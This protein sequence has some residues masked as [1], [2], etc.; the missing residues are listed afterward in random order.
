MTFMEMI[1]LLDE[2]HK[3]RRACWNPDALWLIVDKYDNYGCSNKKV[4]A[5][6]AFQKEN[7]LA[8]DWIVEEMAI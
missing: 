2:K 1:A 5:R 3:A 4:T 8:N 7:F 6:W